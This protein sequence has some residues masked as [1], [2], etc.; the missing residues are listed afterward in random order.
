MCPHFFDPLPTDWHILLFALIPITNSFGELARIKVLSQVLSWVKTPWFRWLNGMA[1]GIAAFYA[2]WFLPV[3]V[4]SF[5][6]LLLLNSVVPIVYLGAICRECSVFFNGQ[7]NIFEA[8]KF[9]IL[10]VCFYFAA[11]A[12]FLLPMAPLIACFACYRTRKRLFADYSTEQQIAKEQEEKK[13]SLTTVQSVPSVPF[14]KE[15]WFV[16][17]VSLICYALVFYFLVYKFW[18]PYVFSHN[19]LT[20]STIFGNDSL[21]VFGPPAILL[22]SIFYPSPI[23]PFSWFAGKLG[24]EK[25]RSIA[26][27]PANAQLKTAE[28]R[29]RLF[30]P[31]ACALLTLVAIEVPSTATR[32]AESMIL[33]PDKSAQGLLILR[34][35]GNEESMLRLCYE[36]SHATDILGSILTWNKPVPKERARQ[37]FYQATGKP[38][39]SIKI[40]ASFRGKIYGFSEWQLG[41]E[42]D[43]FDSDVDLAG[44]TVGGVVRGVTLSNSEIVSDIDI[45]ARAATIRWDM[46]FDNSS[47]YQ[48]EARVQ[49]LVPPNAVVS[50]VLL[51]E[52]GQPQPAAFGPRGLARAAYTAVVKKKRSIA[53]N[54]VR[55]GSCISSMLSC[56]TQGKDAHSYRHYFSITFVF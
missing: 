5:I 35:F 27:V 56:S 9:I 29:K 51:W 32:V 13:E 45:P 24:R 36:K 42:A 19:S 1:L 52:N 20:G 15:G 43:V 16:I 31:V 49:I 18:I 11:F 8:A 44:E 40:P 39:N 14:Y 4:L 7:F 48:H 47:Q 34:A 22:L 6:A 28:A 17:P 2:I 3:S 38:F 46:E 21:A 23:S 50:D 33:E 26:N 12:F 37:I 30:L 25:I 41:D 10:T 53:G 54:H 55:T